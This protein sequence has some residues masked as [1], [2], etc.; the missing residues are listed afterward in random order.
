MG[1]FAEARRK[2]IGKIEGCEETHTFMKHKHLAD[3]NVDINNY[4]RFN[5]EVGVGEFGMNGEFDLMYDQQ[6]A[7]TDRTQQSGTDSPTY[8][9][10]HACTWPSKKYKQ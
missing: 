10:Q 3:R 4:Y 8:P 6:H 1:E 7:A 5:V 9:P 2:L